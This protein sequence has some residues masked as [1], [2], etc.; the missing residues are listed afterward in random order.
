MSKLRPQLAHLNARKYQISEGNW[1][2]LK[3]AA[4]CKMVDLVG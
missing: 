1:S 2:T 4:L 3:A